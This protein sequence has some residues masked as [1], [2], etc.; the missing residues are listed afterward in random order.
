MWRAGRSSRVYNP[1]TRLL[2]ILSLLEILPLW[3][4]FETT[5]PP[6]AGSGG[7]GRTGEDVVPGRVCQVGKAQ[8]EGGQGSGGPGEDQ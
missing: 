1:L 3:V 6:K 7:Q 8:A 5:I 4:F 2:G